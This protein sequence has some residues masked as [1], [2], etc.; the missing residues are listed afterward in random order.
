MSRTITF[1]I[2]A[3]A[4]VAASVA[5][6]VVETAS[7]VLPGRNG[8]IAFTSGREGA[9]DNLAKIF[10]RE[11]IGST[12]SGPL[13][14][15]PIELGAGQSRHASWSPDR[16]KVVF[17]N[18]DGNTQD[19]DLFVWDMVKRE[20]SALDLLEIGDGK[21]SD[22][23]AWSPD[24]TRIAYERSSAAGSANREIMVK[25]VGTGA[26]AV[27]LT[28]TPQMELK[29]AWTPDSQYLW[30]ARQNG[31]PQKSN[32]DIHFVSANGGP[33]DPA[34]T[35]PDV[36]EYQPALSADGTR[37]C[38]TRQSKPATRHR[39]ISMSHRSSATRPRS[40]PR[41]MTSRATSTARGRPTARRS[42]TRT[43]SSAKADS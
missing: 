27:P 15:A 7:A 19:Y 11:T 39:P 2:V 24:G 34:L 38:Y 31:T 8:R 9:N 33:A 23:P 13:A 36:D 1:R 16:T 10:F 3:T 29:P 21:S 6:A 14:P 12:A 30:F 25:T 32:F 26:P 20:V 22:H 37:L 18:G 5:L 35:N 28:N 42:P 17:A 40:S 41:G 43:G 4:L